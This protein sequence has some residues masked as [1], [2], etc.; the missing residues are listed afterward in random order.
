[1]K[2]YL[3]IL[4]LLLGI[5]ALS[6]ASAEE[7]FVPQIFLTETHPCQAD[8]AKFCKDVKP[9]RGRLR[10]CLN[11]HKSEISEE[12]QVKLKESAKQLK[13]LKKMCKKDIKKY[14]EKGVNKE[15]GSI[16]QCL[17]QHQNQISQNCWK[18]CQKK[19]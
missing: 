6:K 19:F 11:K 4:F 8:A 13:H 7:T 15:H 1:M 9:G 14:C 10:K 12:C 17:T 3:A 16:I 18:E 5:G 2:K